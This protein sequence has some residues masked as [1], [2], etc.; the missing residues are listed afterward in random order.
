MVHKGHGN[1]KPGMNM[2]KAQLS[3]WIEKKYSIKGKSELNKRGHGFV[4]V[5]RGLYC[6]LC[7]KTV[8]DKPNQHL[9]GKKHLDNY[10]LKKAS[11]GS[12]PWKQKLNYG[13]L[14]FT[15]RCGRCHD[16]YCRM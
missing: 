13:N 12:S 9:V 8:P 6:N 10:E 4:L 14:H 3:S 15:K 5:N 7:N 2:T 16:T 1:K 11:K